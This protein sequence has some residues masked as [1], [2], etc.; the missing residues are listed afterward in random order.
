MKLH[1]PGRADEPAEPPPSTFEL[2]DFTWTDPPPDE[3]LEPPPPPG[4]PPHRRRRLVALLALILVVGAAGVVTA[5]LVDGGG[6]KPL[7]QRDK[8]QLEAAAPGSSKQ[9]RKASLAVPSVVDR[10]ART[11]PVPRAVAQLFVVGT[12]AQYPGDAFFGRLRGRDWGAVVIG[13][14]NVVDEGQAAALTGEISAVARRADHLVPLVAAQQAGGPASAF[15]DLPPR[16]QPL[17]GDSGGPARARADARAAARGLRRL[18][19]RMTLAPVADVGV[20][21]GPVEDQ[22]FADDARVVTRLTA[23]AVDGYRRG[24][25]IAA[26]GHFPGEGSASADPDV[27]NATV[28]FSLPEMRRRDLRP[29]AAVA[30]RAPVIRM[31]NAVY[32]AWD[33]VTPATALPDAIGRLL[34]GELH[35]RG[36]VMTADLT[37]TAPVLGVGVG[38]AAVQALAAGADVLYVSGGP[39]AQAAAYRAVLRAVRKGRISRERLRLSLQRVLTLKH[40]YGLP[41]AVK[42]RVARSTP[43]RP[44]IAPRRTHNER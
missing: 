18:G 15:P 17:A 5:L 16:A 37:S 19:V 13:P 42:R 12:T 21:A 4:P 10:T 44:K 6:E 43:T 8:A 3:P 22:V 9:G 20:A 39:L 40:R 28:G 35:Y 36:V 2:P 7:S 41:V 26:V 25:V 27:A 14:D 32:A 11:L 23:A 34:R 29:F 30:R 33:G 24:R 31:S 38:T 1:L